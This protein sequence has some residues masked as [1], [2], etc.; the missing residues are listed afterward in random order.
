MQA[1]R[2]KDDDRDAA[3]HAYRFLNLAETNVVLIMNPITNETMSKWCGEL[4]VHVFK[5][6][7]A[8][9]FTVFSQLLVNFF[10]ST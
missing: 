9:L 6:V 5:K 2:E 4:D 7:Y 10:L 1:D 3:G 8:M